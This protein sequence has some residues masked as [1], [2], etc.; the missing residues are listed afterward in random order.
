MGMLGEMFPL[1]QFMVTGVL[2]PG[3]NAHGPNVS[4][5]RGQLRRLALARARA[6]FRFFTPFPATRVPTRPRRAQEF[7]HIAFT[8]KLI[9]AVTVVLAAHAQEAPP[10]EGGAVAAGAMEGRTAAANADREATLAV[11]LAKALAHE[12]KEGCCP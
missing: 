3:S 11:N 5:F 8:K 10:T 1:A 2:G 12:H 7:I 9:T 6:S 4:G